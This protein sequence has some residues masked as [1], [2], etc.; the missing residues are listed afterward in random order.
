MKL[1]KCNAGLLVAFFASIVMQI[2]CA[3]AQTTYANEVTVRVPLRPEMLKSESAVADFTGLVDEQEGNEDPPKTSPTAGWKANSLRSNQ[4]PVA[5]VL[6]LG[7]ER[8]LSSVWLYDNNGIGD[9][10]FYAGKPDEWKQIAT[11]NTDK[12]KHWAKVPLSST[13]NY[14]RIEFKDGGTNIN[15]LL[16]NAYTEAGFKALNARLEREKRERDEREAAIKLAQEEVAKR[17]VIEMTPFGKL[18]LVDEIDVGAANPG[19]MFEENP[20]GA[21]KI[22]T[23]LGR[24]SRVLLP[25]EGE[26]SYMSFRIGRFKLLKPG[27]QYVLTVEY[28]EDTAR[29]WVVM[30]GGNE[31]SR[32]FHTGRTTGD[33]FHPKYVN[34][35]NESLNVPLS[36][37]FETWKLFFTLHDRFPARNFIRG[38]GVRAL[39]PEDGFPVTIAQF[40]KRDIPASSG[41]AVSRI[42]LFE[43]L[44]P[45]NIKATYTLPPAGLPQRHLFG[46][47]EMADGVID[48]NKEEER[49][50]KDR[51]DWYKAKA[52]LM[53]FLGMNTFTKDLLE[54]GAVQHWDTSPLGG[55]KW[56]YFNGN[57]KDLWGNIVDV[58]GK[59]G[60]S[61]LPYYEYA[62]SKGQEG[63]GNQRR[64]KPLT[65]DDAYTHISWI[66]NA[67]ADITDPD[68]FE[69][70]K[71]MLDLTVLREKAK[72]NFTGIWLRPRSQL[73]I[74]FSDATRARFAKEANA[75]N[76]VT[77]DELK[78]DKA[79]LS[80]YYEWWFGKRREFLAA[81]NTYL[82]QNGIQQPVVLYTAEASEPGAYF[83]N[84][85]SQIV[86]DDPDFWKPILDLPEHV[87]GDK[88]TTAITIDEVIKKDLYMDAM[89]GPRLSWGGWELSHAN[90][91]S[92]PKR[93]KNTNG[94][95]QTHPFNRLYTVSDPRT[96]DAFSGPAGLAIIRHYTLNE[97]MM[98][99]RD[100]KEKL[101]YFV[102]DIERTGPYCMM[103]EAMAMANGNPTHIGYLSGGNFGRGFP[104]Y[105]RAFNTAFLSLPA[106][107]SEVV[108]KA[109]SDPSVVVRSIK[110]PANGTYLAIVNTAMGDKKVTVTLPTNGKIIDA[111]TGKAIAVNGGKVQLSLYPFQLQSLHIQ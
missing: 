102:G 11:Y 67:N 84:W 10:V 14:L 60:F 51:L 77:R 21:T 61:V 97:N 110:T 104:E 64:A 28:P 72:A 22:E 109:A 103:A 45:H 6:D 106:L 44:E 96:F 57:T 66:E 94:V 101:G 79:L 111:V 98:F 46:R 91:E 53:H 48:S 13:T 105:V 16:L 9:I 55:N 17:P 50:L 8:H 65:R 12:Y 52:K 56:A 80:K 54:F 73:P 108:V 5:V 4:Y 88:K 43:V 25:T 30:S 42:R 95:L 93:Y 100:D 89:Q 7:Q 85:D 20:K 2:G 74:S 75:D 15:E 59:E 70:F 33:A 34:N 90:P 31:T 26:S 38:A 83:R 35:L 58:M 29:S 69:D 63:L 78:N 3:Q 86:T 71:K 19:H 81:M 76:A 23:I 18:S 107:P 37:R 24:P 92:D 41:A 68:T 32:G 36:G 49:G 87:K 82:A 47:E 27:A 62:G 39:L 1:I 40:S 99:T